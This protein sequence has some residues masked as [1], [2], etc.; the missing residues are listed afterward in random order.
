[1]SDWLA[2]HEPPYMLKADG[3]AAG[4]GVWVLDEPQQLSERAAA[5]LAGALG[6]AGRHLV[7]EEFL[8]GPE[9]SV[10]YA[11][12]GSSLLELGAARDHKRLLSGDRGPNT[13]GMGAFTPVPG[14]D[15]SLLDRVRDTIAQPTITALAERGTP[16]RGFLYAGLKL[17]PQGPQLLEFNA[18][19]GDPEAQV[20]LPS[21]EEDLLGICLELT[22]GGMGRSLRHHPGFYTGVVLAAPGYPEL[23]LQ[24]FELG[25]LASDGSLAAV[26]D[27]GLPVPPPATPC[28]S[29]GNETGACTHGGSVW[30]FHG[31]T[32]LTA[33]QSAGATP[34]DTG[35]R[36]TGES[37]DVAA[38]TPPAPARWLAAGGRLLTIVAAG[39]TLSASAALAQ[40]SA[41][42]IRSA[43]YRSS[44]QR[45]ILREDIGSLL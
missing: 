4:K 21:L 37:V 9:L 22:R 20:L 1:M 38:T 24:G 30:L 14:V 12:D 36:S 42:Y 15:R 34:L 3:L 16:Y 25:G 31:G 10:F 13:G 26:P 40:A 43:T 27:P 7:L 33:A 44:G 39:E 11:C 19:L 23:P 28:Q 2:D 32:R 18:R 6:E 45:L 8:A 5:L 41:R 29:G 35:L 17:T